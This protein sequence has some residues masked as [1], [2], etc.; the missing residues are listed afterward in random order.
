M[1]DL[2]YT[3]VFLLVIPQR[4]ALE[5]DN[6]RSFPLYFPGYIRHFLRG[7]IIK[8]CWNFSRLLLSIYLKILRWIL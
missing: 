7:T 8:A 6:I 1:G 2:T 5:S 4:P 3:H